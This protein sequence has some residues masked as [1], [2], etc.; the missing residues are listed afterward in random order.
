MYTRDYGLIYKQTRLR[1]IVSPRELSVEVQ[2]ALV[3]ERKIKYRS[4]ITQSFNRMQII[5]WQ[6][7]YFGFGDRNSLAFVMF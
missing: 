5:F 6:A 2:A 1:R 4:R 7:F 3:M